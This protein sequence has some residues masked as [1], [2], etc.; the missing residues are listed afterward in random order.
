M[1][2]PN[3]RTRWQ[4]L[5]PKSPL[6]RFG[7][8][9]RGLSTVEY[10]IILVLIAAVSVATWGAFG[11]RV[12]TWLGLG[13]TQID[14]ELTGALGGEGPS[15]GGGSNPGG[16]ADPG[17]TPDPDPAVKVKRKIPKGTE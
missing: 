16:G 2:K 5:A 15:G 8:D 7:R 10:V 17:P 3:S 12:K 1:L 14:R 4:L 6:G 9:A 11:N 13:K